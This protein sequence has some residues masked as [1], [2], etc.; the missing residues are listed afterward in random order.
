[1]IYPKARPCD[2]ATIRATPATGNC[3]GS[4]KPWVLVAAILASSISFVDE[5]V[6]NVALPAIE[7]D[8][9]ASAVVVQWIVNAD[10]LFLSAFL[11]IGG[12]TGDLFGRRRI[13]V[14]GVAVFAA[15]SAWCG[16]SPS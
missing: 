16:L 10:T 9:A 13:F 4:S 7:T 2:Q 12:A 3:P 6:L 11:L 8:L 14:I 5:S 1:M 15:A